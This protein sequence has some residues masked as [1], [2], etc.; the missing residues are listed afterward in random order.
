VGRKK[1]RW[2]ETREHKGARSGKKKWGCG[3]TEL[4]GNGGTGEAGIIP[5]K[6]LGVQKL[7]AT[8][9]PQGEKLRPKIGEKIKC[10]KEE[11]VEE[12][13]FRE[14]SQGKCPRR[15]LKEEIKNN[16]QN[17][18]RKT[19]M[20]VQFQAKRKKKKKKKKRL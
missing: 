5:E 20:A 11:H 3:R 7:P 8:G 14:S 16:V 6:N 4:K 18:N 2:V 15:G 13:S 19:R 10:Q 12:T 1:K 17:R 9:R